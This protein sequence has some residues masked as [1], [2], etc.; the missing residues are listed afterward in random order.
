MHMQI[1]LKK[2]KEFSLKAIK[3]QSLISKY[4]K[5]T[6]STQFPKIAAS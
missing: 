2:N 3:R 4:Q 5:T 6:K 1:I